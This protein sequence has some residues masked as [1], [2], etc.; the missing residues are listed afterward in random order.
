MTNN[1]DELLNVV[2]MF[3]GGPPGAKKRPEKQ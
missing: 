2:F 1:D 3:N